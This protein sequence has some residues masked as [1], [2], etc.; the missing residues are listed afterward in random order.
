MRH[1]DISEVGKCDC[2]PTEVR[3]KEGTR[4][5]KHLAPEGRMPGKAVTMFWCTSNLNSRT[6]LARRV[7]HRSQ[8]E[9]A[10][11]ERPPLPHKFG[12]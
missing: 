10:F 3:R 11:S 8:A 4:S 5:Y 12:A 1:R 6:T 7:V 9:L 2:A